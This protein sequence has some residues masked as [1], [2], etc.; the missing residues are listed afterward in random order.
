MARFILRARLERCRLELAE[1]D[2]RDTSVRDLAHTW[3]FVS[4]SHFS[5]VFREAYGMTPRQWQLAA[6]TRRR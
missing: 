3:G 1:Y 2:P 6:R 5:R 4:A